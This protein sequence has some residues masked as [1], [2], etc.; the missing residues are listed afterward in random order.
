MIAA[1]A[2]LVA[3]GIAPPSGLPTWPAQQGPWLEVSAGPALLHQ[4]GVRGFGTGPLLRLGLG[5][6]LSDYA[7][8]EVWV[9][10][11]V[12]SAPYSAPGDTAVAGLGLG[13][14]LRLLSFGNEGKLAI[15]ARLGAGWQ[16]A[17]AGDGRS[18]PTGFA[19]AQLLF[20][21][22]VRRFAVGLEIDALAARGTAGFAL[23]PSLR[24]AL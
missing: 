23:L 24:C 17:A 16:G 9:S 18:G 2:M 15:W 13:G 20:Q 7:A 22:F 1:L 3:A 5:K 11:A 19:G 14:R 8:G 6:A 12:Q 10:G 21:P 4:T